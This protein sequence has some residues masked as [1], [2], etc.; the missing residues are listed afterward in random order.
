LTTL[1]L[2]LA[3]VLLVLAVLGVRGEVLAACL[4]AGVY[5]DWLDGQLARRFGVATPA[6]RRYDCAADVLFY[7]AVLAGAW[8][9][10]PDVLAAYRW[11]IAGLLGLE[12]SCQVLSLARFRRTT[13]THC[14][15]CKVWSV[16]LWAAFALLFGFGE[17]GVLAQAAIAFGYVA[18]L[19][20][21]LILLLAPVCPVDVPSSWHAWRQRR[22]ANPGDRSHGRA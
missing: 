16:L 13:S 22:L 3:P 17:V 12:A 11:P 18:Y 20:V 21:L 8:V 7:L 6:L 2:T 9:R 15:S 5:S 10:Y 4:G 1:R 19:D 14:W